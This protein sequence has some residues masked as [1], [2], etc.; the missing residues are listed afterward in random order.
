LVER[1]RACER[2]G[3]AGIAGMDHLAPPLADQ[4]PM[5]EAM[6][7]T[8]WLAAR[9]VERSYVWFSDFAPPETLAAFGEEVIRHFG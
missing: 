9:E 3:F 5:Y 7:T 1:A 4:H 2:A 8:N 6:V